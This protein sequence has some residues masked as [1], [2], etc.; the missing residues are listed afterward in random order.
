[1]HVLFL[2]GSKKRAEAKKWN[3]LWKA[4]RTQN[5]GMRTTQT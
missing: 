4:M 5:N 1:M 2:F 3:G